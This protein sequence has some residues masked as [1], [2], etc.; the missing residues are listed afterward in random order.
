MQS[1]TA[2]L[3]GA[4]YRL[5]GRADR[6]PTITATDSRENNFGLLR[7]LFAALVIVSHAP[8]LTD[9]NRS[10]ELLTG[11]FGTLSFGEFAVD[12]FFLVSGYLITQSFVRRRSTGDFFLR[13]IMRIYPGYLVCYAACMFILAPMVGAG[14]AVYSPHVILA[15]IL[16][17][18]LLRQPDAAGAFANLHYP[19]LNGA[20]WTIS[21]E[22]RCYIATALAG[23][24][25]LYRPQR[26]F[27]V[28]IGVAVLIVLALPGVAD[29]A[30]SLGGH[31]LGNPNATLRFGAV[32][33]TGMLFYLYRE[34]ITLNAR[35]AAIAAVLLAALLFSHILAEAALIILGSYI[36][37]WYALKAPFSPVSRQ[38][39]RNDL[40]YGLYLY[41]W[42]VLNLILWFNAAINPWILCAMG[43]GASA[44]LATASWI[45]VERPCLGLVHKRRRA[46]SLAARTAAGLPE[47]TTVPKT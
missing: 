2:L 26:R 31:N 41:G 1:P 46:G 40:S 43:L 27:L 45:W 34:R 15:Q 30:V 7:L 37:F 23:Y 21:Y 39:N 25:G 33:G 9:G 13:R 24:C 35:F 14:T 8:E 6:V 18:L 10:R 12:G 36:V 38:N 44:V 3:R 29:H 16:P 47:I 22:F 17:M 11:I 19:V 28:I 42:P 5:S 32:F 20:M 4:G